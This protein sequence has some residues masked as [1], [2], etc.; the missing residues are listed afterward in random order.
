MEPTSVNPVPTGKPAAGRVEGQDGE[1]DS[2]IGL[3]P[4][5]H[6]MCVVLTGCVG[7][8]LYLQTVKNPE[9]NPVQ[10]NAQQAVN[11]R[12]ARNQSHQLLMLRHP[13]PRPV[14]VEK[15]GSLN[16]PR[17]GGRRGCLPARSCHIL[18]Q[19]GFGAIEFSSDGC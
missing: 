7:I 3:H 4:K 10:R 13:L 8:G 14:R 1:P 5:P 9:A 19:P 18:K 17:R 11:A 15:S 2:D 6:D 12:S 16:A